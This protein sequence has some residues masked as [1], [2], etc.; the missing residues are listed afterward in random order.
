MNPL[1]RYTET[2]DAVRIAYYT[3]GRG[4]PLVV[5]SMLLW[6]HL[7]NTHVFKEHYRS[8][9]PGGL[10]HG[11]Q[12]V[13]YDA[14][15][16]GLSDRSAID[17]SI[18][19]Q[20]RDLEAVVAAA[21][22]TRFALF[23]RMA[24]CPA[25]IAYA[26]AHPDSVTH[27][28]LCDPIVRGSDLP[29]APAMAGIEATPKLTPE[30]WEAFT[31]ALAHMTIGY[32]SPSLAR[33]MAREYRDAMEPESYQ[34]YVEWRKTFDVSALLERIR[35]PTLVVSPRRAHYSPIASKVAASIR[36]ARLFTIEADREI[37]GRWLPEETAAVEEFLGI[38]QSKPAEHDGRARPSG[39][40]LTRREL[41]VLA[42]VVAGR[43]NREIAQD[44]T[45]S[46]R[47]VARH[48]ANI[49]EKAGVH[50][51]AEITAYALRHQLV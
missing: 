15:G 41:E 12:I 14:R 28:V 31:L 7:G 20:T 39:M 42:L 9:T 6:G 11:M 4:V 50:G 3:M 29:H 45:L 8:Q 10:G 33:R 21:G 36:D 22:L 5:T 43:S 37:A 40:D 13:R 16:T 49:Y 24:G 51:R 26:V 19:A 35:L 48:I 23:A 38:T 1:I 30:Q 46:E 2:S 32:S 25:A 44:L 47:T 18:E 34:A 27:L 17:F